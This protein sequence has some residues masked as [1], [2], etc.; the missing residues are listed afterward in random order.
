MKSIRVGSLKTAVA[1]LGGVFVSF[2]LGLAQPAWSAYS[3]E[4]ERGL[5]WLTAQIQTDGRLASEAT[6]MATPHQVRSEAA[7][8]F[9]QLSGQ[10]GA[11]LVNALVADPEDITEY[12]ARALLATDPSE[13]RFLARLNT[14]LCNQNI[15]GGFG[16]GVGH[17]SNPL[18]TAW[19]LWALKLAGNPVQTVGTALAYLQNN[20][21]ADGAFAVANQPNAY[22]TSIVL[23]AL[24]GYA[25]QYPLATVISQ[26][27]AYL[28]NN[29]G[30]DG[31]WD[32]ESFLT[33]VAYLSI[34]DFVAQEP[35]ATTVGGYLRSRQDLDGSWGGDPYVTALALRALAAAAEPPANPSLAI[36]RGQMVDAQT[37]LPLS[38]VEASLTGGTSGSR[39]T[40]YDGQ[41]EFRDLPPG[42][43]A[44]QLALA[45]YSTL[46]MTTTTQAGQTQN[47]GVLQM[48]KPVNTT[49]GTAQG[50]VKD[51]ATGLPIAGVTVIANGAITATTDAAGQ[52]QIS[53]LSP[54][55][56]TLEAVMG[57]YASAS[58]V[59]NL[60]AGGIVI[61]SPS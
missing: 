14:L 42:H 50:K 2:F 35:M 51:A 19:A 5:A 13:S 22:V 38:G 3:P 36:L 55:T 45:G 32:N 7:Q 30:L 52:Y 37:G 24:H 17:T 10:P 58:G 60:V 43:Y 6:A 20:Q 9:T 40:G 8:S 34:R 39:L 29:Q 56:T 48:T 1:W 18:D 16:G 53:N 4:V 47:L 23:S 27:T 57:G 49:T 54:G 15:D 31:G 11:A 21:Q 26:A 46:T 41:F 12:L 44:L 61:F 59:I 33:A 28:T 25:S